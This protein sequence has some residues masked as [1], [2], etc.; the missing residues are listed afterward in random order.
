MTD[1]IKEPHTTIFTGPTK[2]GKIHLVLDFIEKE[3]NK[4]F[5]YIVIIFLRLQY[6]KTYHSRDWIKND[7]VWFIEPP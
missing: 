1:Y 3:Y 4:H 6:N 2:C 7:R 5:N